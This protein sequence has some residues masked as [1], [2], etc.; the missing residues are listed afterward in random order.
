MTLAPDE[1]SAHAGPYF[2]ALERTGHIVAPA[3]KSH[4]ATA[5]FFGKSLEVNGVESLLATAFS[6]NGELF[7][8]FTC[9]EVG[10]VHQWTPKQ[11]LLLKRIAARASLSLAGASRVGSLTMPAML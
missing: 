8:T 1:S 11:L 10:K 6:L 7:G 4:P 9:T 3:A 2:E 5:G